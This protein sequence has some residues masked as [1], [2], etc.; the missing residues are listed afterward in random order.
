MTSEEIR[1]I[2]KV[3]DALNESFNRITVSYPI[4]VMDEYDTKLGE[5]Y[6]DA[7]FDGYVFSLTEVTP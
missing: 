5:I 7:D 6:I 3:L 4:M 2:A 1:A